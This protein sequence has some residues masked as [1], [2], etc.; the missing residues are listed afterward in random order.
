MTLCPARTM[1][2]DGGNNKKPADSRSKTGRDGE[3]RGGRKGREGEKRELRRPRE[4]K[5]KLGRAREIRSA[6][7]TFVIYS[8]L[9][10]SFLTPAFFS[11]A[12][13]TR[14]LSSNATVHVEV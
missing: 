3:A 9:I 10:F 4:T 6:K 12:L 8:Y 13:A 11:H 5:D 1:A 7:S 14:F 2:H